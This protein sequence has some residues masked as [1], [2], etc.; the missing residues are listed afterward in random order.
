VIGDFE[1]SDLCLKLAE[2]GKYCVVDPGV[3][4]FHLERKS[5][6]SSALGWRMN[7]TV[8]NAWQHERRWGET[9]AARQG[10]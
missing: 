4:L 7:L 3:E 6:A 2:R 8:Y 9:I 10:R 5:Q 1:D